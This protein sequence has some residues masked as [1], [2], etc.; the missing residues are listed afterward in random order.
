MDTKQLEQ[1]DPTVAELTA[2]RDSTKGITATDLKDE[3][4][5]ALVKDTR[6]ALKT[7]RVKIEKKGKELREDANAF[8]KKVIAKEKEL[9]AII[10][11]EEERLKAI[12][13]E[14]K[15][16]AIREERQ[17]I[18]PERIE[19]M[20]AAH[21]NPVIIEEA[22]LGM[23]NIQFDSYLNDLKALALEE[24]KQKMEREK[25]ERDEADRIAREKAEAE[26]NAAREA[27]DKRIQAEKDELAAKQKALD[28][29]KAKFEHDKQVAEAAE[30]AKRETEDRLK[31]ES[32]AK[33]KAEK[34]LREKAE[35]DER[36]RKEEM[37]KEAK[38]QEF[39][40]KHGAHEPDSKDRFHMT[41]DERTVRL[42]K[43]VDTLE[44]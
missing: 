43:L 38:F 18:M 8:A 1:F 2:L 34:E 16:L 3:K 35:S 19:R 9:I 41:Y 4:Q 5:L 32:E 27:E 24:E 26:A 22:I 29:E 11:P 30:K 15:Q 17:A 10:E 20:K 37:E 31:R 42:Y 21:P 33:E 6:I 36:I 44:I 39:L 14:A 23:D 40:K 25:A 28:D 7:A 12:E 13:E